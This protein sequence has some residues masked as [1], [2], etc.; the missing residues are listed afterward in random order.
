VLIFSHDAVLKIL[1]PDSDESNSAK[2]LKAFDGKGMVRLL[3][4]AEGTV[5]LERLVPGT[6]LVDLVQT[7]DDETA[8]AILA[9][10]IE[11]M[12]SPDHPLDCPQVEDW[13]IAFDSYLRSGDERIPRPLVNEAQQT[14]TSLCI[15][16]RQRR[17]L[18]GDLHHGNVLF[19]TKRGW[20]AID[21]KGVVGELEYELGAALRNPIGHPE[22]Y[23]S[24]EIVQRR[25][26]RFGAILKLDRSRA[27]RWAFAQAVLSAIWSSEDG[28]D[29]EDEHHVLKLAEVLRRF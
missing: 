6:S 5:L 7:G 8:T 10:V 16:Q 25:L 1:R 2:V 28:E 23:A 22:L 13:G 21:P 24:T 20:L 27:L 4:E 3:D 9:E 17:L 11:R 14:Y 26:D 18:H 15:S 12:G 29:G 19:D